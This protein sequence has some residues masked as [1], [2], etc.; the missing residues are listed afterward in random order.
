MRA[1]ARTRRLEW[2]RTLTGYPPSTHI[3]REDLST[4]RIILCTM[5]PDNAGITMRLARFVAS[6]EYRDLDSAVT[7][8]TKEVIL[9]TLGACYAG[10][11]TDPGNRILEYVA[12]F[13]GDAATVI[14]Q[15]GTSIAHMAALANGTTA[16][17]LDVDDGHRGASAH[18]GSAVIPAALALAE[19]H[20]VD[21]KSLVTAVTAGYEAMVP[22][23]V[24]VQTSHRERG[25]HATATTGCFGAAAAASSVLKLDA[26]ETAHALG[27]GGTQA[28][29][30]FEFLEN[31]SMAKRFH[32]G[33]AAMAG[34]VAAELA[35]RGFDG[36][37][38][39]LEGSDGFATAFADEHDF[40]PFDRLGDPFAV[41]ESYLKPYPCCRHI[42]GPIDVVLDLRA[43]GI[44]PSAVT[45]ISVETYRSA[46]HHDNKRIDNLLDAQMSLPYG[47][48]V[49]FITGDASLDAFDPTNAERDDVAELM[50]RVSVYATDEMEAKYS[51]TRPA[52]VFVETE[53]GKRYERLVEY[54][55]GAAESPLTS[56]EV[57][58]KFRDLSSAS[59]G[60]AEQDAVINAVLR[61]ETKPSVSELTALL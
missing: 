27:L 17:A 20:N 30:L 33:R 40:S 37:D 6:L 10:V 2:Y 44:D 46:A 49:A 26:R 43:E 4:L 48:A 11:P 18:P 53:D 57:S 54:P 41:T 5:D 56:E 52:T 12:T 50:Q 15:P 59:L 24:A 36:P 28:G 1:L 32:P 38:T 58:D 29:G 23:A 39:I 42:H 31:G 45:S 55:H 21:G 19:K 51:E 8:A 16:H 61:L 3:E 13:D 9:D 34:V 7:T 47:V 14:E 22:T 25:F 60:R 35:A